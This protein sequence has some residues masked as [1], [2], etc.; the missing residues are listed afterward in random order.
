MFQ[1]T[2]TPESSLA[3]LPVWIRASGLAPSQLVTLHA[4]LTDEK[5]VKFESRAF[6]QANK[7]GEVDLKEACSLGGDYAG[8]W[9]MGLFCSMKPE[10]LFHRLVKRDVMGSPY[11]VHINLFGYPVLLPSP[12]HVPLATCTVE[13]WYAAPGVKRFQIKEGRV[14]GALFLPPGPG[15]FPGVIDMFGGSGGLMESRASLL[16]SKGFVVL[17]LAFL[18]YDDLPQTLQELDLEYFEEAAIL[19]LNHSK[20]RGPGLGVLGLSKG[21]EIALAMCTF[22]KQIVAVVCI[23]GSTSINGIPLRFRDIHIPGSRYYA[24]K[25]LITDTGTLCSYHVMGDPREE[26]LQASA[27]PLEKAAGH[28]LFVVG[29]DDCS[30]MSK[31]YAEVAIARAKK[32]GKNNCTLL[33]YPEAGHLIEPPGSPLCRATPIRASPIPSQWGGKTEPHAKAQEHSWKEIQKFF[34]RH[35][36]PAGN[37]KL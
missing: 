9:P 24:E 34:R 27:I 12:E 20:V 7:A 29:E 22:L 17:A 36:G 6:Y 3:D 14:R 18:A 25:S 8:V 33:S 37:S 2:V 10:K 19:L 15:P 13:R 16:A 32:Y 28:V 21:A 11:R 30:I 1:L 5:G 26:S 31:L 4:L 23:N 35:L